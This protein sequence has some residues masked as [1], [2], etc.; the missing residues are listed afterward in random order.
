MPHAQE[1]IVLATRNAGKVR[2]LADALAAYGLTVLGLD[3]FPE[4]GEIDETGLTFEENA[5][6]KARTVAE[7]T[8]RIAVADDSGLE[9]DALDGD[10]GVHSARYGNDW[11]LLPGET[12]DQRNNR[13]ILDAMKAVP[14]AQRRI[15]FVSCMA[16]CKPGGAE[17]VVRGTWE[18]RL[19]TAPRGDNGFGYDPLFWDEHIGRAAAE[20]TR[21]E[22]NARSHRGNALRALLAAWPEFMAK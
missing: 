5:L 12:K 10:P 9:V 22:K 14:E 6:L 21:D 16:A 20:L 7:A 1:T 2:E 17:T 15:R 18:G 4:I 13:K 19:L 3:A 11:P 8:G